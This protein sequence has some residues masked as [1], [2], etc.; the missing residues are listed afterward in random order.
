MNVTF[1]IQLRVSQQ[2]WNCTVY[3]ILQLLPFFIAVRFLCYLRMEDN[4]RLLAISWYNILEIFVHGNFW[5]SWEIWSSANEEKQPWQLYILLQHFHCT[6]KVP[7]Q[8]R[9]L[10]CMMVWSNNLISHTVAM[11]KYL[12]SIITYGSLGNSSLSSSS[13]GVGDGVVGGLGWL[14]ASCTAKLRGSTPTLT[15]SCPCLGVDV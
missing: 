11:T 6:S 2:Q 14:A 10:N 7:S 8:S 3:M 13:S 5:Q 12:I 9:W 4:N 1:V 15:A